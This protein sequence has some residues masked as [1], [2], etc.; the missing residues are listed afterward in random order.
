[1]AGARRSAATLGVPD[2]L[3]MVRAMLW[4]VLLG[5]LP[6]DRS[7]WKTV[8]ELKTAEYDQLVAQVTPARRSAAAVCERS[9][10]GSYVASVRV[11]GNA[12]PHTYVYPEQALKVLQ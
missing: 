2:D 8:L 6:A 5:V 4:L 9:C 12:D 7:Q 1:V 10:G 3:P 11:K